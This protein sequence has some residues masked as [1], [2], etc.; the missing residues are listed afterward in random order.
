MIQYISD[1]IYDE[2]HLE[3]M[4]VLAKNYDGDIATAANVAEQI[5]ENIKEKIEMELSDA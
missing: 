3:I 2:A 4:Q 5:V 1:N